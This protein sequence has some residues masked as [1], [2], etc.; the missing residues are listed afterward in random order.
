M[1]SFFVTIMWKHLFIGRAYI[2][3]NENLCTK[4]KTSNISSFCKIQH[5]KYIAHVPR[6]ENNSL[7]KQLLFTTNHNKYS[8]NPWFKLEKELNISKIQIQKIMRNKKE[9]LSLLYL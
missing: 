1:L 9:F 6:L 4:T 2:F 7:Q 8:R 3:N 5:L